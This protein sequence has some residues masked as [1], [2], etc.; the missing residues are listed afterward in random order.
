[1]PLTRDDALD[2]INRGDFHALA[3]YLKVSEVHRDVRLA[4]AEMINPNIPADKRVEDWKLNPSR[5]RKGA[6]KAHADPI[7]LYG[8]PAELLYCERVAGNPKAKRMAVEKEIADAAGVDVRTVHDA[9]I[10]VRNGKGKPRYQ[11]F[12]YEIAA[13]RKSR[14]QNGK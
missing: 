10:K 1:M 6:P 2:A 9:W 8:V 14:I 4:L 11:K 7:L 3:R 5:V 12:W 13:L